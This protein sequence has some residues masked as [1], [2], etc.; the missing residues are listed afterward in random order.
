MDRETAGEYANGVSSEMKTKSAADAVAVVRSGQR[1]FVQGS[2]ATPQT[3]LAALFERRQELRKVELVSI[4]T[5]GDLVWN[6]EELAGH[7]FL[8]SLFVS[9]NVR[10]LVN[11]PCGEYVPVFLSEIPRLFTDGILPVDVALIHV[12]PPD[13]HGFCSLGTSVDI[14]RS[15]IQSA[16]HVVAQVNPQ[17]P[18]T[19]GDGIIHSSQIDVMVEVEDA[20]PE[21]SY[22][23]SSNE[24]TRKIGQQCAALIPDGATLQMG[25]GCIPDA[26]LHGL[27]HHRDLGVHTEMLSDGVIPLIESGVITNAL[28][29]KHRG[30][31]VTGFAVGTRRL[32][33][34]IDDNPQFAFLDIGYVNDAQVIRQNP[35]VA[36]IN[37]ALEIDLTGQVCA[38]SL[39]TYQF[40]GVGGQMDFIRG[41]ALSE[42]GIPIIAMPSTTSGNVSRIVPCLREGA[43]VTTTR[44]NIHYVV[45]EYGAVNLFGLNLRQR[46]EAL[47]GIAH[48]DHREALASAAFKRFG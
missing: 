33:D 15:A 31:L 25:I 40:S 11:G 32:Y 10:S 22:A 36:A 23:N 47:V 37:S 43:G 3:L 29:K 4:T 41:A 46:A 5:L 34:F 9:S 12:S 1:V 7:F 21:V 20:L 17:M 18:R 8:N 26:V 19:H 14:V 28:K 24:V 27:T 16:R 30:K 48:P 39:G 6:E 45:T 35:R 42:G 44:A 38:D 13:R 2:A